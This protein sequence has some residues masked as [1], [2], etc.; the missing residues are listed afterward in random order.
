MRKETVAAL[1]EMRRAREDITRKEERLLL[2][3]DNVDKHQMAEA[4]LEAELRGLQAGEERR[5]SNSQFVDTVAEQLY[6]IGVE[7]AK[8]Q[9]D[10]LREKILKDLSPLTRLRKCQEMKKEGRK[11]KKSESEGMPASRW[12]QQ[13]RGVH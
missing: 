6:T 13:R 8:H 12:V 11:M 10:L 2:L 1:E 9:F 4:E 5:G 3:S 7:K